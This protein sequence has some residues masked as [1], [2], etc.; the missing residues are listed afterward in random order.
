MKNIKH[1]EDE[2]KF[3]LEVGDGECELLYEFS[4]DG[5]MDIQRTYTPDNLRGQGLAKVL[6]VF[7]LDF[8][9]ENGL[10]V[11]PTCWYTAKVIDET[12]KYG[13]LL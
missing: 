8:A 3:V 11:I 10:K 6:T 1:R 4:L 7:V 2:K 12:P 9:L 5:K 13:A